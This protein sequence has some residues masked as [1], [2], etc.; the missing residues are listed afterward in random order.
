MFN[1]QYVGTHWREDNLRAVQFVLA[2]SNDPFAVEGN[3][4]RVC[5]GEPTPTPFFVG[6]TPIWFCRPHKDL[7]LAN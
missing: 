5:S 7:A 6:N 4:C 1:G 2:Q 3:V